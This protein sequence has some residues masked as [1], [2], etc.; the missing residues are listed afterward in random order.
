MKVTPPPK[1]QFV[2]TKFF[3]IIDKV[4]SMSVISV[5]SRIVMVKVGKCRGRSFFPSAYINSMLASL[6]L[7]GNQ[8]RRKPK[9]TL[10]SKA[11]GCGASN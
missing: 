3:C 10:N 11:V 7:L 6:D 9:P 2:P 1:K 5:E 4:C 8:S